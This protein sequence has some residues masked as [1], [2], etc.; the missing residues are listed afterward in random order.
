MTRWDVEVRSNTL[1][2]GAQLNFWCNGG[3]PRPA[4]AAGDALELRF[5]NN[6]RSSGTVVSNDPSTPTIEVDGVY[7][8]IRLAT[9]ADDLITPPQLPGVHL[10]TCLVVACEFRDRELPT[11]HSRTP[12]I[13]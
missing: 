13:G 5:A 11:P 12:R 2:P 4:I 10:V 7:W 9:L 8:R 3:D 6:D 1:R